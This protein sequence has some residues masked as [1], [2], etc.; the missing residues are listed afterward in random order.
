MV[1]DADVMIKEDI[2]GLYN[3]FQKMSPSEMIGVA[4]DQAKGFINIYG[5]ISKGH[6]SN[7]HR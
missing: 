7:W 2:G 5:A 4:L 1:L 6:Q 3:M